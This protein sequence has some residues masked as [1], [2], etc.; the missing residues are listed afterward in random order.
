VVSRVIARTFE[1]KYIEIRQ[2]LA[3]LASRLTKQYRS[4]DRLRETIT[5]LS[6]LFHEYRKI[7]RR[8]VNLW[9]R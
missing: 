3:R 7:N 5:T 1:R 6:D 2:N 4:Y 8:G 9:S